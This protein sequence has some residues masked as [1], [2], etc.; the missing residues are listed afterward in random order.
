MPTDPLDL[1]AWR[2]ELDAVKLRLGRLF[3]RKDARDQ[4]ALYL[5]G[6]L[7]AVERENGWRLAEAAGDA[8][9]DGVQGSSSR[10]RW[11]A[12]AVRD[13]P[14]AYVVGHL[15][16]P[17]AALVPDGT[18]SLEKGTESAGVQ[19]RYSGT[20]G[21]IETGRIGA[22]LGHASG[23]GRALIGRAPHPP[24]GWAEGRERRRAAGVPEEAALA[25]EP[26]LGRTMP[27]RAFDAGVP[28]A[29]VVG[30]SVHGA[31]HGL[32]RFVGAQGCG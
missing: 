5:D 28:C 3:G 14:R 30:D 6:L 11:A 2:A 16:D 9:P 13:D 32:R 25:A 19:R 10:M 23:R 24:E 18:G 17:G 22:F 1:A 8:T 26:E 12:E 20:A 27:A 4:A 29:W 7:G 15:G 31:D 21:R